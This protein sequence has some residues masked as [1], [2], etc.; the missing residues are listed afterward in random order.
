MT[1][2]E[3]KEPFQQP[4]EWK[5]EHLKAYIFL[6]L[7]KPKEAILPL[8]QFPE[9]IQI[10]GELHE[11]LNK[12]RCES[13]SDK[14][15]RFT[16]IGGEQNSHSFY[17]STTIKKAE[18]DE[19]P[20]E[21]VLTETNRTRENGLEAV[22][23]SHSHALDHDYSNQSFSAGDLYNIIAPYDPNL[24]A[25]CLAERDINMFA[26]PSRETELGFPP[27]FFSQNTFI[28]YWKEFSEKN[29]LNNQEITMRIAKKHNLA[30]YF[31]L[32]NKDLK[33]ITT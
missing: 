5:N 2:K 3:K 30:I 6:L 15:E 11:I 8:S 25:I 24:K 19:V 1:P 18:K 23:A 33:R 32:P 17:S 26:F 4:Q 29:L 13:K 20:P 9:T 10:S 31:G 14:H 22:I 7:R 28:K 21:I 27:M 12:M 16:I